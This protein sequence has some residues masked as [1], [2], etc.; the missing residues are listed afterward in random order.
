[1]KGQYHR[2]LSSVD[3]TFSFCSSPT[4]TAP[5]GLHQVA[6][7]LQQHQSTTNP[8]RLQLRASAFLLPADLELGH[9]LL[10]PIDDK[11]S[12]PDGQDQVSCGDESSVGGWKPMLRERGS[13]LMFPQLALIVA[14]ERDRANNLSGIHLSA[15]D[16]GLKK[17]YLAAKRRK[18][19]FKEEMT[20]HC[21]ASAGTHSL[22]RSLLSNGGWSRAPTWWLGSWEKKG[23]K[24]VDDASDISLFRL[25]RNALRCRSLSEV[26][27]QQSRM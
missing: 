5:P 12:R 9:V 23:I 20:S 25:K 10:F 15:L 18:G 24:G 13:D 27:V 16:Q 2:F 4:W 14:Q 6:E 1:M 21:G 22:A 7:L 11:Q 26:Q 17:I 19:K 3:E 8:V